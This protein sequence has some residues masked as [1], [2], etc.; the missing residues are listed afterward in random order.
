M[1]PNETCYCS[2]QAPT[3]L[4][5]S[6]RARKASSK[7]DDL[8][9]MQFV[10][11]RVIDTILQDDLNM[12]QSLVYKLAE[13][14]AFDYYHSDPLATGDSIKSGSHLM[15]DDP[16]LAAIVKNIGNQKFWDTSPLLRG[17][18]SI[19]RDFFLTQ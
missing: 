4:D 8:R 5:F 17:C 3:L 7:I 1:Q 10:L 18:V 13:Q 6:P 2:L 12:G 15:Q 19:R 16:E 14:L 11:Q 9:D